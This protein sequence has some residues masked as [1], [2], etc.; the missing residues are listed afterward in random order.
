[1]MLILEGTSGRDM[2]GFSIL[3]PS[4]G[5]AV[6]GSFDTDATMGRLKDGIYEI[7]GLG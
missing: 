1:M 4:W 6:N 2:G 3:G 5:L 7:V